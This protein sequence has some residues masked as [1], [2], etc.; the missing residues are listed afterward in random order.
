LADREKRSSLT[1]KTPPK[2]KAHVSPNKRGRTRESGK[3]KKKKWGWN[4]EGEN[5]DILSS[6]KWNRRTTL[7][8]SRKGLRP[9]ARHKKEHR[10]NRAE[11]PKRKLITGKATGQEKEAPNNGAETEKKTERN[12][13]QTRRPRKKKKRSAIKKEK[14]RDEKK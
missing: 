3:K 8:H 2:E 12:V 10:G 14:G 13:P 1:G 5:R 9:Q 6:F 7:S 4:Q 11:S